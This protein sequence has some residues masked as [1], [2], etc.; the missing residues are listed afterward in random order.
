[1]P[2]QKKW[3]KVVS[4]ML[5]F[6]V[7]TGF[8]AV[9]GS[10]AYADSAS[11]SRFSDVPAGHWAEKHIAKL[12][13]Q[14]IVKGTN[15]AF[16]PADNVSQQ[17]AIALA[18][19]FIGK[20][21]AVKVDDAIVFPDTFEVSTY[22]KPYIILAFQEGLLDQKAEFELAEA[23]P[24]SAWGTQKATREWITKLI[25]KAIG[26]QK[27]AEALA[28]D[29][30]S[31]SD[32]SKVGSGYKGYVNAAVS[33]QLIK[34]ITADRFD[35]KGFITRASI[36]TI[37]SRAETQ[38]PVTYT[39]QQTAVMTSIDAT[40]VHLYQNDKE[41]AIEMTPDTYVYRFDSEKPAK[42]ADLEANTKL[43]VISSGNK[44][45]Y[46]EQLD[47]AKQVEKLKG[48][49]DRVLVNDSKI[50]VWIN[51]EPVAIT[52]N[53]TTVVTDGAGTVI[54]P[55]ALAKDSEV[56]ITRDTYRTKPQAI[57]IKVQSAPINNNAQGTVSAVDT[58]ASAVTV[59]D[60]V[61]GTEYKFNVSP[62]VDVIWQGQILD[63]GLSQLRVGDAIS[64]EVKNS[65]VTKI[66]ITQ[67]SAKLIRG[68]FYSASSD[69]KTIQYVKNAGTAQSA[70]EAKFVS[71]LADVT[72]DGLTGTTIADLV[73][74]DILDIS[75]NS[76]DQ[77]VAIKVVNRN[78][79][80]MIGATVRNY[81]PD[82]RI[83]DFKDK[84]G[85][86]MSV[87]LTDKTRIDLNGSTVA[88]S[89]AG[90]LLA[91]NRKLTIG[92]TDNKAVL[93]Q[94][95]YKYSGTVAA[96][97]TSQVSI[98]Q[99]NGAIIT[100][101]L[102][103]PNS[104]EIAGKTSS[105]I[106]DVKVGDTVTG[107]LN[108]NQDK[109]ITLQVHTSLQT[110]VYAAEIAGK[111]LKVK[112]ADGSI[113]DL[114]ASVL[115]I[116]NELGNKITLSD[117]K[118]GQTGNVQ[119]VGSSPVSYKLVKVTYGK[120]TGVNT[121]SMTIVDSTGVVSSVTLGDSYTVVKNGLT[122]SSTAVLQIGDRVEVKKD[123]KDRVFVTV[124]SGIS[125]KFWKYNAA[126]GELSV[127]R[128][129]LTELN[130][131]TVTSTTKVTQGDQQISIAQLK[132]GDALLLY[133]YQNVLVEIAKV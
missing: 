115:D 82:T 132:D 70:L 16:K 46:V 39:G 127:K 133:F 105:T 129:T 11:T 35:P 83:L 19:R 74:G 20:E 96:I 12:A 59:K 47:A 30:I 84:D 116:Y 73:K 69:G 57:S 13:T 31:F 71:I 87:Y 15:G 23:N 86:P 64:Y 41:S 50:W 33:L 120:L 131:Y 29:T 100:L 130:T 42:V 89:A 43:L 37:F 54:K 24:S 103:L 94:F 28:N 79:T 95:V 10:L 126:T 110:S 90:S 4:S 117:L 85:N 27:E 111:R 52:Y 93:I 7:L 75:L 60:S 104:I 49:V 48:T 40:S 45:L 21:Q 119:Y 78:V 76:S 14:G 65:I 9:G 72:I 8:S 88:V 114:N 113:L 92:V 63:G 22:F 58:S 25:V 61:T 124:N 68:E 38:F 26:K 108:A 18:I 128:A 53:S 112:T 77:V 125:K 51:D 6:S 56:E 2:Q 107:L 118:S 106:A 102:E 80:L 97:N 99:S 101:P 36:A 109:V 67:T 44:A 5:V 17:E 81:E 34:G 62:Q 121:G 122:G 91:K 55:S 123:A 98:T 32:G 1:M 3:V 66:T